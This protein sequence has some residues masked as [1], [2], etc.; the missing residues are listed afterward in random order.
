[1]QE[2]DMQRH[3]KKI[4]RETGNHDPCLGKEQVREN[5]CEGPGCQTEQHIKAMTIN[6]LKELK[7]NMLNR[8]KR[9]YV[10]MSHQ[11]ESINEET[12]IMKKNQREILE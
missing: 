2:E 8:S 6:V 3:S 9:R 7:K 5:V 10:T 12:E 4:C 11:I 1:M